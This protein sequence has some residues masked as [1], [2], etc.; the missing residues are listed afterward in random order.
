MA[1]HTKLSSALRGAGAQAPAAGGLKQAG[2]FVAPRTPL[3]SAQP[4]RT[5]RQVSLPAPAEASRR[6]PAA[7]RPGRGPVGSHWARIRRGTGAPAT[8]R[9]A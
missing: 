4:S 7:L 5:A 2:A 6:E 8:P 9:P 3:R 1:M